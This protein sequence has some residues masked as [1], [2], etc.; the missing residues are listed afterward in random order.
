MSRKHGSKKHEFS[1]IVKDIK[2]ADIP[3]TIESTNYGRSVTRTLDAKLFLRDYRISWGFP[4]D[5]V[6]F[7]MF[8]ENE[9]VLNIMPWDLRHTTRSTYLPAARN[10]IHNQFLDAGT[11]YLAMIDSDVICPRNV[12]DILIS[13]KK[14]LV[15]GWYHE[16]APYWLNG[17]T[18]IYRPCVYDFNLQDERGINWYVQR[19]EDKPEGLEKVA[20][21]GAGC[22]LMSRE[23][24]LKLGKN[25]YDM[26]SGG[27]DMVICKKVNDLGYDIYVDWSLACAH[28]GVSY[29]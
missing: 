20:G 12:I 8:F 17:T 6:M 28:A 23:L 3:D 26:N 15:G 19:M 22:L 25:P 14:H 9:P 29:V 4:L 24:A 18:P 11:P 16:K 5:E 13:H 7:S 10:E 2:N 27:E 1:K 21:I